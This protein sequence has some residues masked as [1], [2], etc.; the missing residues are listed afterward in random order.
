MTDDRVRPNLAELLD[1]LTD[2]TMG[3]LLPFVGAVKAA[4]DRAWDAA[5][6]ARARGDFAKDRF[7]T[8]KAYALC[9][10]LGDQE[11][12]SHQRSAYEHRNDED[13][14]VT[15]ASADEVIEW[16]VETDRRR[17]EAE[18]K[19]KVEAVL[20]GQ[21]QRAY[22]QFAMSYERACAVRDWRHRGGPCPW[23]DE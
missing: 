3:L 10:V 18:T 5:S 7:E 15:D 11:R 12:L 1:T 9:E 19:R 13:F 21:P 2:E 4:A 20:A 8:G 22:Y 17:T 16:F 14:E 23:E 6:D